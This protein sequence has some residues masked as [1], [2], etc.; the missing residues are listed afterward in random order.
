MLKRAS[1]RNENVVKYTEPL[2]SMM[3][4]NSVA[5][6]TWLFLAVT[7]LNT[8]RKEEKIEKNKIDN[9]KYLH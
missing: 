7:Q 6:S 9:I 8:S 1:Y 5:P 3:L 2:V 4:R